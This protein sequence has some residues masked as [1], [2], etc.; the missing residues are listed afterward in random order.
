MVKIVFLELLMKVF[1]KGKF[2]TL[3]VWKCLNYVLSLNWQFGWIQNPTL[4]FLKPITSIFCVIE[5]SGTNLILFPFS[6]M[7]LPSLATPW[8]LTGSCFHVEIFTLICALVKT[9]LSP[10]RL[11]TSGKESTWMF[12][13]LPFFITSIS[14]IFFFFYIGPQCCLLFVHFIICIF[15]LC[16]L[17]RLH[18]LVSSIIFPFCCIYYFLKFISPEFNWKKEFFFKVVSCCF[19]H[20]S[21]SDVLMASFFSSVFFLSFF[22]WL[23]IPS[24]LALVILLSHVEEYTS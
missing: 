15:L 11:G 21:F 7:F 24:C 19:V 18:L 5:Q 14:P 10:I 23:F 3:C 1:T 8:K 20:K 9:L 4:G 22:K 6:E 2:E 13:R 12:C 16:F 17:A